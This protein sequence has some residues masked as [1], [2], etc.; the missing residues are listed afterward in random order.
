MQVNL[1]DDRPLIDSSFDKLG[2]AVPAIALADLLARTTAP[3]GFVAAV[4]GEWGSGKSTFL[5]FVTSADNLF[6]T[7]SGLPKLEII[8]F[9]PWLV[10]G[11]QDLVAAYFKHLADELKTKSDKVKDFAKSGGRI[12]AD[13]GKAGIDNALTR[14]A[15]DIAILADGGLLVKPAS[16][17]AKK[18]LEKASKVL[19]KE[20][21]L[22]K[23]YVN[24]SDR[25]LKSNRRFLVV[26]DE[27]DRLTPKEIRTLLN[28]VKA[29]GR[30]PNVIYLLS[31]DRAIVHVALG[32]S[33]MQQGRKY[34]EKI[35]QHEL[36]L[37]TPLSG[38]V[39]SILD[40]RVGDL[41]GS[42]ENDM[43]WHRYVSAGLRRWVKKPRDAIRLAGAFNFIGDQLKGEVDLQD[44][45][46]LEGFRLFQPKVYE[47]IR[48]NDA[49]LFGTR[50]AYMS[51]ERKREIGESLI[52][53]VEPEEKEDTLSL[54]T[55]LFPHRA[56]S[57]PGRSSY[58]SASHY[59]ASIKGYVQT[60]PA[61]RAYF[62]TGLP[63]GAIPRVTLDMLASP[64]TTVKRFNEVFS[65]IKNTDQNFVSKVST[66]VEGI[67][68]RV[69]DNA[70]EMPFDVLDGLG[71]QYILI[72]EANEK[73]EIFKSPY[74]LMV[75]AVRTCLTAWGSEGA[76]EYAHHLIDGDLSLEFKTLVLAEI[77]RSEGK[78]PSE[79]AEEPFVEASVATEL[80]V[81]IM[82]Q[83]KQA[84][85][86]DTLSNCIDIW[87]PLK[88]WA[89]LD[90]TGA[91]KVWVHT[92]ITSNQNVLYKICRSLV[93]RTLGEDV[94]Y[95][96]RD[97]PTSDYIDLAS[98]IEAAKTAL[99]DTTSEDERKLFSAINEGGQ[100]FLEDNH[101]QGES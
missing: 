32:R 30:L 67:R 44:V 45:I 6:D 60:E 66:L 21:S 2:F 23:A 50:V 27:I 91:A 70:A 97:D 77:M 71:A 88:I 18:S 16:V 35:I 38:G 80:Y 81:K 62:A 46:I 13:V 22:Q 42:T 63:E 57:I 1:Y 59:Q 29:V 48:Q 5:N 94:E 43:R 99:K 20:P 36:P 41:L 53:C 4:T 49:F 15:A 64:G 54:I 72:N 26:I 85:Q 40:E 83:I 37:P 74:H 73:A 58:G 98:L 93:S 89:K 69:E 55:N 3:D 31:Y 90:D 8:R 10:S 100:R 96:L 51:D 101:L 68:F 11:R 82:D 79:R 25:L 19:S 92:K 56:D 24:L 47:W 76:A 78:F 17:L 61:Y 87:R 9:D 34:A 14:A 75:G 95:T 12:A 33:D 52:S 86:D 39:L 7:S 28:M 65:Q 84:A